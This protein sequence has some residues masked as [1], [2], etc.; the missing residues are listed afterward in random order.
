MARQLKEG[1]DCEFQRPGCVRGLCPGDDLWSLVMGWVRKQ[2]HDDFLQ[3]WAQNTY[4]LY[5]IVCSW[6]SIDQNFGK[7]IERAANIFIAYILQYHTSIHNDGYH[8][9]YHPNYNIVGHDGCF[10][11]F[12]HQNIWRPENRKL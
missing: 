11:P 8:P 9:N 2:N 5:T 4:R 12:P 6:Y 3:D 7:M 10:V 1:P